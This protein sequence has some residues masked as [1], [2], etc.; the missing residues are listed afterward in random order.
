MAPVIERDDPGPLGEGGDVIVEVFLRATESVDQHQPGAFAFDP[1]LESHPI[2]GRDPHG[3]SQLLR[4]G[5]APHRVR[6]GAAR[7]NNRHDG[8]VG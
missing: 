3:C 5:V 4:D 2:V 1:D 7:A 8:T 6:S